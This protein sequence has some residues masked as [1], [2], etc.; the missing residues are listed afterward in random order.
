MIKITTRILEYLDHWV[1]W[2]LKVQAAKGF[3]HHQ[4]KPQPL[5]LHTLDT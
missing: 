1:G 5:N 2:T 4:V 3:Q